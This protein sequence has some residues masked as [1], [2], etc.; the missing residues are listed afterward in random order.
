MLE[1]RNSL[2]IKTVATLVGI[3][4]IA[5]GK[6]KGFIPYILYVYL[7]SRPVEDGTNKLHFIEYCYVQV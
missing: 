7:N 4:T 3:N 5:M 1:V 6:R 2:R